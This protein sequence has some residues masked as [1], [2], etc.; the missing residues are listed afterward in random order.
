MI[1]DVFEQAD[2]SIGRSL[3]AVDGA[4][5]EKN[6]QYTTTKIQ[7]AVNV[8]EKWSYSW[9]FKFSIEKTKMFT[10][11]IRVDAHIA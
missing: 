3:F 6:V 11:K 8:V 1:N 9:G 5:Q 10:K 7:E 4:L 2:G